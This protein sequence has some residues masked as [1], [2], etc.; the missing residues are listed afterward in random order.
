MQLSTS[1]GKDP[2]NQSIKKQLFAKASTASYLSTNIRA[3]RNLVNTTLS[4]VN[5]GLATTVSEFVELDALRTILARSAFHCVG[6]TCPAN[7]ANRLTMM[8]VSSKEESLGFGIPDII[9]LE[10]YQSIKFLLKTSLSPYP[11]YRAALLLPLQ[12][13]VETNGKIKPYP[14]QRRNSLI[15]TNEV[16][17]R[18]KL[19]RELDIL[20]HSGRGHP[21][22]FTSTI[23]QPL[24]ISEAQLTDSESW[25]LQR[26]PQ[27]IM[28]LANIL[29]LPPTRIAYL[30]HSRDPTHGE[31]TNTKIA[32]LDPFAA[33]HMAITHGLDSI[34]IIDI[35]GTNSTYLH[36]SKD[37]D[38]I[39]P[40]LSSEKKC[41]YA[42]NQAIQFNSPIPP[43]NI[44][45]NMKLAEIMEHTEFTL[46]QVNKN[47]PATWGRHQ[48]ANQI[49]ES[50][51]SIIESATIVA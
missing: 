51:L 31:D 4:F 49:T 26:N 19:L 47:D 27:K 18:L 32:S 44:L 35:K 2:H 33:I 11:T 17:L 24:L 16:F 41:E 7:K 29:L 45:A 48:I 13:I 9:N 39:K 37:R 43:E 3:F 23:P 20:C 1:R 6:L 21:Y 50:S 28:S 8:A 22:Y 46:I 25:C 40:N 30:P 10:I 36:T 34:S 5:Y 14:D 15:R 38:D 12:A 42:L